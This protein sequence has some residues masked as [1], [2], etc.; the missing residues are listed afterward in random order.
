MK[1]TFLSL[2]LALFTGLPSLGLASFGGDGSGGGNEIEGHFIAEA[3]MICKQL[4][5][6]K[7]KASK[8]LGIK[9]QEY[10][11]AVDQTPVHCAVS[12]ELKHM[13]SLRKKAYYFGASQT[14]KLDCDNYYT[15]IAGG[16][17]GTI[18]RFHEYMRSIQKEGDEY[19]VSS[20]LK[21]ALSAVQSPDA[22]SVELGIQLCYDRNQV[23][24]MS[25]PSASGSISDLV[26]LNLGQKI[27][28]CLVEQGY[29]QKVN[30][31]QSKMEV[32]RIL[33]GLAGADLKKFNSTV[34]KLAKRP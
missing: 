34:A 15:A 29:T 24:A 1:F 33:G 22:V 12:E 6:D 14:I 4:S 3:R 19:L 10:C 28:S 9:V 26:Q 17:M 23:G 20:K 8:V 21:M 31:G 11:S 30:P 32:F 18:T 27:L 5:A 16:E 13:Q 25:S 2:T 7:E